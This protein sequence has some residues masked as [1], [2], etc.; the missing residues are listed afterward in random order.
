MSQYLS[1]G[2]FISECLT[3][4]LNKRTKMLGEDNMTY[5]TDSL[6]PKGIDVK[7]IMIMKGLLM[8]KTLRE[9]QYDV[10]ARSHNT[11][12]ERIDAMIAGGYVKHERYSRTWELTNLGRDEL[13]K[14]TS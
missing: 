10:L 6:R 4:T 1:D 12:K 3:T 8:G 14:Y 13:R 9:I 7:D 5:Y 2:A 11:V